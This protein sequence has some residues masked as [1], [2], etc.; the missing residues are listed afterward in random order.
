[1]QRAQIQKLLDHLDE[2]YLKVT[3]GD[4]SHKTALR[5]NQVLASDIVAKMAALKQEL[6]VLKA[7]ETSVSP[8]A[9]ETERQTEKFRPTVLDSR[10][11]AW[12]RKS[13]VC[14]LLNAIWI[15]A[16]WAVGACFA[17]CIYLAWNCG[18]PWVQSCFGYENV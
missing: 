8:D 3:E 13:S 5:H 12:T 2:E 14:I 16:A 17:L 1:M 9:C 15:C 4:N 11:A 18:I 7:R 6:E 10:I